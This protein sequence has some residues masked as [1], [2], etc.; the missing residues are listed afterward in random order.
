MVI[1]APKVNIYIIQIKKCF[2]ANMQ[3]EKSIFKQSAAY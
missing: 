2:F 3:G 1:S